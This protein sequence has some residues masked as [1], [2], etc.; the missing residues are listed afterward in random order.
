MLQ[1]TEPWGSAVG[2]HVPAGLGRAGLVL[3][4]TGGPTKAQRV[5]PGLAH[6]RA[7]G[8]S[9]RCSAPSAGSR[10]ASSH[11]Q[12]CGLHQPV[13]WA[14]E[15]APPPPAAHPGLG[16]RGRARSTSSSSSSFSP[17]IISQ[18]SPSASWPPATGMGPGEHLE[19]IWILLGTGL[20]RSYFYKAAR[21]GAGEGAAGAPAPCRAGLV[22]GAWAGCG[23]ALRGAAHIP[24]ERLLP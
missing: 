16:C 20:G 23:P 6:C 5:P 8:S 17:R 10:C 18:P 13:P 12:G 4:G 24:G 9:L 1:R 22:L 15:H 7:Q 14:A 2:C 21:E 3:P 11:G 19:N